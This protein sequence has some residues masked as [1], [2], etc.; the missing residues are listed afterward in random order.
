M[1][2]APTPGASIASPSPVEKV[3]TLIETFEVVEPQ[4]KAKPKKKLPK[5]P[6]IKKKGAK[7]IVHRIMWER[8][9]YTKIGG[10]QTEFEF[11]SDARESALLAGYAGIV[12]KY[13]K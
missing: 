5:L 11:I 6:T 1:N 8:K 2:I 7:L 3:D 10:K 13:D 9:T 4:R 12:V